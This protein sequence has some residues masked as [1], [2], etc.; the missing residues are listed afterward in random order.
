MPSLLD[1]FAYKDTAC[2][3]PHVL[4]IQSLYYNK[5]QLRAAGFNDPPAT[6][7]DWYAQ[8]LALRGR[9]LVPYTHSWAQDEGLVSD[10]VRIAA[11]YGGDLFGAHANPLVWQGPTHAAAA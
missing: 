8:M 2:A 6:L 10:F 5:S 4:N 9:R 7:E 11:E 3:I 1:A